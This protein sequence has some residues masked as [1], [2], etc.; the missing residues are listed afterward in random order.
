MKPHL[1]RVRGAWHVIAGAR[2]SIDLRFEAI[3]WAYARNY[4]PRT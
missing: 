1:M 3:W 2:T 4:G